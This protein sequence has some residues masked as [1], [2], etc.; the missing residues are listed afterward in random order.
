M[1]PKFAPLFKLLIQACVEKSKVS[2][3]YLNLYENKQSIRTPKEGKQ[4]ANRNTILGQI[5]EEEE[6]EV[7]DSDRE[8]DDIK[9]QYESKRDCRNNMK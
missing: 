8:L 6:G 3:D 4:I 5:N 7:N 1:L 9:K 2:T